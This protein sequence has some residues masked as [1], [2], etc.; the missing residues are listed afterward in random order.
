PPSAPRRPASQPPLGGGQLTDGIDVDLR[1]TACGAETHVLDPG[2][3]RVV[4]H[5]AHRDTGRPQHAGDDVQ[6]RAPTFAEHAYRQQPRAPGHAGN[7]DT[8]VAQRAED[9]GDACPMP[10]AVSRR[11]T[12]AFWFAQVCLN[13]PV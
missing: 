6:V 9:A 10:G 8:V 1:A 5:P 3:I 7:P 11:A 2:G 12:T 13:D 4:R